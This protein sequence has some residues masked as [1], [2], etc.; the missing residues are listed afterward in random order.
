MEMAKAADLIAFVASAN[1]LCEEGASDLFDSFGN[2]CL[3]VFRSIGLP[4]TALLIRDLPSELKQRNELKKLCTSSL[5]SE[6]PED[7]KFYSA[8]TRDDLHKF[9]L[10]FKEQGLTAPHWRNQRP[11]L[12]AQ[13]VVTVSDDSS[14][15]KSTLLLTG[16]MRA[17]SLS[18]NQLVHV[19]GAGDFQLSKIE[20]LKD[21]LPLN[22]SKEQD[23]MDSDELKDAKVIC[24][25]AL[26][27]LNQEPLL[28]ENVSDPLAREQGKE[29]PSFS[30]YSVLVVIDKTWPTEA[31]TAEADKTKKAAWIVGDKDEEDSDTD[32]D[33]NDGM[34]LDEG[35]SGFHSQ[36]RREPNK[37]TIRAR[38]SKN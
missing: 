6:F 14:P 18:V 10:L 31:E 5:A 12:I 35:E 32:N 28:V 1:S 23:A 16:Y 33:D 25:L 36:G 11:Y 8:D 13:E 30:W 22:A 34:V 17:H 38:H 9:M 27:P 19:S 26:D 29:K 21:P 37:G 7:S 3:S 24:C 4:S 20:I 15:R 2:Q